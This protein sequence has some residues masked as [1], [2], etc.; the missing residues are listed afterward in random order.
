M[1][2]KG[3]NIFNSRLVMASPT[4]A[5]DLDFGGCPAAQRQNARLPPSVRW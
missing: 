3:L 2:N 5:S 4:T 1:E